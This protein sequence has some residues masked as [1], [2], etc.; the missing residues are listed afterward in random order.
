MSNSVLGTPCGG[1]AADMARILGRASRED[2]AVFAPFLALFFALFERCSSAP[3]AA[4]RTRRWNEGQA[5][6]VGADAC[7]QPARRGTTTRAMPP[8]IATEVTTRRSDSG[9]ASSTT[10]PSAA[11]S[12][13]LSCT[14]AALV[15]F[16]PPSAVY[17]IA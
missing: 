15:T 11:I 1:G 13:T 17:Q 6:C 3:A 9:S 2:A 4:A 12:G 10:P 5:A 14:V 8:R 7:G 16:S